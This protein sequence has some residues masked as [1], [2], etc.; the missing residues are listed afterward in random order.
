MAW[1][2]E[3]L[4]VPERVALAVNAGTDIIGDTNDVWSMKEAYKRS[5]NSSY[6][7]DKEIPY[8]FTKENVTLTESAIN[9]ANERLLIEMFDLG[10]FENPYKDP[11]IAKETVDNEANWNLA[12]EAHQKSVVLLKNE[13]Q[14]LPLTQEKLEN[15]KVYIEYF[16]QSASEDITAELRKKLTHQYNIEV[17]QDYNKADYTLLFI[18]PTSGNYFS[19]TQGYLELDICE[20]KV[21]CDVDEVGRPISTT[22]EETT[23]Q[24]SGKIKEISEA[25]RANGGKVISNVNFTLAWMLGNVEPYSDAVLAGFDTYVDATLDVIMG[26][27]NPTGKMPITLP[28]DDSVLWVNADGVC[29]SPND[30]PG[31]LKDNYMPDSMKDENGKAYAYKDS[32]GNYYELNFGLSYVEKK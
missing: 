10:L 31:Y 21:A 11:F 8:D 26:K 17:T 6:Y 22:H 27:Y 13:D 1:G 19:A 15:K 14:V 28:K 24:N 30:V 32:T 2:V 4:D 29:I 20:N 25:V 9:Q 3:K 7:E 16:A 18:N 23:L 5:L 12:Y